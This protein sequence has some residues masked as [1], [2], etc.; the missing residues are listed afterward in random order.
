[1][2]TEFVGHKEYIVSHGIAI[3]HM[4]Y[5]IDE[6]NGSGSSWQIVLNDSV[7]SYFFILFS[8]YKKE[9]FNT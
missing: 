6:E 4:W 1:M 5:T 2:Y 8:V 3:K 7:E 9:S